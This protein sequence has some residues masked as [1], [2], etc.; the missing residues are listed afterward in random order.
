LTCTWQIQDRRTK[1]PFSDW[2]CSDI[3]YIRARSLSNDLKLIFRTIV[4]VLRRRGI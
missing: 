1:I 4:R 2:M 3:R